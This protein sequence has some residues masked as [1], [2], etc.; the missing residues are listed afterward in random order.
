MADLERVHVHCECVTQLL[1][2]VER[3]LVRMGELEDA[4]RRHIATHQRE[5]R[6]REALDYAVTVPDI[7]T[8]GED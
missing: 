2:V 3:V 7:S 8:F 5:R 1:G 6:L 4:Q